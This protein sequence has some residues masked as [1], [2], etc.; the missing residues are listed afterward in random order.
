M[1]ARVGD[2][3]SSR[4]HLSLGM[5]CL[6]EKTKRMGRYEGGLPICS[7]RRSA[8]YLGKGYLLKLGD[9]GALF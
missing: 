3:S 8:M 4:C 6:L 2:Y 5:E 7:S 9:A 1:S